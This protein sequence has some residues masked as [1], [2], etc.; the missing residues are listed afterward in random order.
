M[1]IKKFT[2]K[3]MQAIENCQKLAYEYGNQEIEQEHLL[4]SLL[5]AED[6]L[7][8]KLIERMEISGQSPAEENQSA[9]RRGLCGPGA[10][11]GACLR[12]G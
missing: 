5:T 12:R 3:S 8:F 2:Q 7:I 6:S 4:Y 10:E 1:N 11:Q 9:G